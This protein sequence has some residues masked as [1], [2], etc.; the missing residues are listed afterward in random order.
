[1]VD[2]HM[3]V[4]LVSVR[5]CHVVCLAKKK[6]IVRL[7]LALL[8]GHVH[9]SAFCII[10]LWLACIYVSSSFFFFFFFFSGG[11]MDFER[12]AALSPGG[13][14]IIALPSTSRRG[15]SRIVPSLKPHAGVVTTRANVHWVATEYGAVFLFG[16]SVR[17]RAEKLISIAHPRHREQLAHEARKWFK[18]KIRTVRPEVD[19][20]VSYSNF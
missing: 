13:K 16:K 1:M 10:F 18:C 3:A 9:F 15:E 8:T 5:V 17:E 12:G 19:E 7:V 4:C 11:Q 2:G 14:P 6:L 20:N